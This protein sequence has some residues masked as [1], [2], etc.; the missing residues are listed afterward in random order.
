MTLR[1]YV[2]RALREANPFL[3]LLRRPGARHAAAPT[4]MRR[5]GK[6]TVEYIDPE[7]FSAEEDRAVG[8][9]LRADPARQRR[10]T[11]Y[12]GIAGT[13]STDD[14]DVAAGAGA[15]TRA[16]PR[17]RS[18]PDGLQPGPPGEAGGGAAELAAAQRRS[19]DAVPALAVCKQLGQFF[20]VRMLGGEIDKIDRRRAR[21]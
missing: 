13:N 20:D 16:L 11:G 9:G 12:F 2:S 5:D 15:R 8:F 14:V 18:D 21:S 19:G 17:V 1:F 3:R 10:S 6:V 7:P 4:P